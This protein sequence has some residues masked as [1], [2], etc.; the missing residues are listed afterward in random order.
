MLA[1]L[2]PEYKLEQQVVHRIDV[3]VLDLCLNYASDFI[4]V[5]HDL[6]S[7]S[8]FCSLVLFNPHALIKPEPPVLFLSADNDSRHMA[9]APIILAVYLS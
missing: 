1:F 4:F 2:L 8:L 5:L 7:V 9:A 6:L 3:L